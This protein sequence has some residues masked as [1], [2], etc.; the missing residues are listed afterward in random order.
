[1]Q[2]EF[3]LETADFAGFGSHSDGA[4]RS[5]FLNYDYRLVPKTKTTITYL[6]TTNSFLSLLFQN[7]SGDIKSNQRRHQNK[8][9]SSG[10]LSEALHDPGTRKE[11]EERSATKIQAGIRGFLVRK[12]QKNAKK[13]P[14]EAS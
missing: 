10:S 13:S 3:W 14:A 7:G 4:L 11:I 12:R 1:M 8:R 6:S 2:T 5:P 9:K